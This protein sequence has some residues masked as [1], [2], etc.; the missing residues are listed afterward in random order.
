ME[1]DYQRRVEFCQWY[2]EKIRQD[3]NFRNKI[4]WTDESTFTRCG[5]IN[6]HNSHVY[7][8]ENPHATLVSHYQHD[9]RLNVWMGQMGPHLLG[10]IFLPARLN[11]ELFLPCLEND[12]SDTVDAEIPIDIR[13]GMWMQ[14]DGCPSHNGRMVTD[15][16]NATY[17]DRWIG[18]FGAKHYPARSPDFTPLDFYLWSRLKTEVYRT[19]V[20]SVEELELKIRDVCNMI[21]GNPQ[22]LQRVINTIYRRC[23]LGIRHG[24]MHI[25]Q[26]L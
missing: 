15:Y 25:E 10:P 3:N 11:S 17:P 23:S 9:F 5:I 4:L 13:D 18:R 8:R 20:Q 1:P 16:L 12:I 26:Y 7:A 6:L 14:M 19:A 24:G 21:R 2:V 22:E